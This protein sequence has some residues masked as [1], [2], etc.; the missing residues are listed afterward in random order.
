MR[1]AVAAVPLAA[2]LAL[3]GCGGGPGP[4]GPA[5]SGL[6]R[7]TGEGDRGLIVPPDG[8]LSTGDIG[9]LA[10]QAA[11]DLESV[12][13]S[14]GS[15]APATRAASGEE[16]TLSRAAAEVAAPAAPPPELDADALAAADAAWAGVLAPEPAPAPI[17][18]V[19]DPA[20][21][22]A[23]RLAARVRESKDV[24]GAGAVALA[25]LE[26]LYP[27]ALERLADP[28]SALS[29]SLPGE[30]RRTLLEARER[31]MSEPGAASAGVRE[32]VALLQGPQPQVRVIRALF[33]SRVEGFGRY[34]SM[35][36]TFVAGRPLRAIVYAELD[37]FAYRAAREGDPGQR[38]VPLAEQES[39]D[40]SQSLSLYHDASGL[41]A[42]HRPAQTV[43][44]TTRARRRDFYLIQQIELPRT[45]GVGRYNLKVTVKDRTSGAE[46]E[47]IIPFTIVAD[48]TTARAQ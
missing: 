31:V 23:A 46:S 40:L 29:R 8:D 28:A 5:D 38:G 22:A 21:E 34:A 24:P 45:L 48:A 19:S 35:G 37:Q 27:G 3:L 18:P 36:D 47:A 41:L 33:C 2:T 15:I 44:E 30:D 26:T 39:V 7:L 20:T 9:P 4:V 42:W 6:T 32:A 17:A 10:A 16:F 13:R 11:L 25:S 12:L 1:P 43:V 14:T